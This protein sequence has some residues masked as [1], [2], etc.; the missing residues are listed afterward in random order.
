MK[1]TGRGAMR[2][3]RF[4]RFG[5]AASLE[6]SI[7]PAVMTS[8]VGIS[9]HLLVP[10]LPRSSR[11]EREPAPSATTALRPSDSAAVWRSVGAPLEVCDSG[12]HV[13]DG[14]PAKGVGV[15][16]AF[17]FAAA[18]EQ[19]HAVAVPDQQARR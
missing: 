19:Q 11:S 5:G 17:A 8:E 7:V 3:T 10:A 4:F 1:K 2:P 14:I 16:V 12:V 9:P 13:F 15:A 6:K 18:V